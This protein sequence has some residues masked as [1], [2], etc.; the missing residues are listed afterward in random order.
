MATNSHQIDELMTETNETQEPEQSPTPAPRLRRWVFWLRAAFV[1]CLF[2]V[3]FAAAAAVMMVDREITAPTWIK[4]RIEARVGDLLEGATLDFGAIT[5]RIGRDLHPLVR[6][7]DTR[8]ID[9]DGTTISRVPVVEGLMSPRGLILQQD[10]LMQEVRLIG[11]QLNLRRAANGDVS[12]A[13]TGGGVNHAQA[14][15]LPELL[16]QFDQLFETPALEALE[17]V[18]A[19]GMI[20]NFD[21]ARA[22][23]SWIVDGG[24]AVLDLRGG[25]TEIRGDFSLLSGRSEVTIVQL[26]Y[27]S[28]RGSRAAQIGLNLTNAVATDIA[29][30]S[31]GLSWLR[32]IDAPI[33]ASLRT[34]LDE[35][36]ALGP[37]NA[38]LNLGQGAFQPNA[39]ATPVRFDAARAYFTYNPTRDLISFTQ[40][41]VQT[42]WGRFA[43]NGDAYLRDFRDGLPGAILAQLQFQD[44]AINP[45]GFF[46]TPP[47]VSLVTIDLRA[48][49]DPFRIEIGQT[50]LLDGNSRMTAS[51]AI[52]ATDAG[53]DIALDAQID[54][55]TPERF[56]AFWPIP[57]KPRSRNW[58]ATNMTNGQL[59]NLVTGLRLRPER[60]AEFAL[61]F[62]FAG[63]DIKFLRNIPPINGAVGVASIVDN[64]F[65]V[66][67]DEGVVLA[68]QGGPMDLAGSNFAIENLRL[69]PSP[70]NLDLRIDSTLTAALSVLNQPPFEYMDKANLP[71]TIADGLA[72][73]QGR[74][75]WPLMPRPDPDDVLFSMTS[76]LRNVRSETLLPGRQF[77]APELRVTA[78]KA[79]LNIAGS[80]QVGAIGAIGVWDRRFGDPD[81]P[82]SRVLAQVGLSQDFLDEFGIALPPGTI[83]G[84]GTGELAVSLQDNTP[85]AFSLTS[86]LQG[87]RVAIPAVGWTKPAQAT[88]NLRVEGALG[89]VA[90]IDRLEIGGAGFQASG[91][92]D[93]TETGQLQAARFARVQVGNWLDAPVT[94]RGRG[95]GA[96]VGV[97]ISGGSLDLR[98]AQFGGG[99]GGGGPLT[100]GLD[101]LQISDGISLSNFRGD[102]RGDG[103]LRGEFQ[104]QLNGAAP[105]AGTIAPRNG[106]TAVR[107]RSDNAGAV[108]SAAGFMRNAIGG[109]LDLSLLPVGEAGVFDGTLQVRSVRVRDAPTIA[110]LLD[111]ISVVGLLQQMD[112]QGLA[113]EEVD[114]KFR[115]TPTRVIVSEASAVGPGLG[116]SVDG[117]Y[118]LA[119][120]EID[121]QGVVSPFF[122][123]N[124]I[125]SFLTRRGEG[126]IGFNFNI[127]GTSDAPQVSVN[128]L[129]ALTPGMFREI[130]RRPAPDI[131]Q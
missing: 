3:V 16:D 32:D 88:G 14:R 102:F 59:R 70:A 74:I 44:V 24:T 65:A 93:L 115:L 41:D 78:S 71:V 56:V 6:L 39:G 62:E 52:A 47:E 73:T 126:L 10:V 13:F 68:P 89:P 64:R 25:Q 85:P 90:T 108:L 130:F 95:A 58:F 131:S 113:F 103:G 72:L 20:I 28:P 127:R 38:T 26:S 120:K 17:V 33:K 57:M 60:A 119:S 97:E 30:Q 35:A 94:L 5:V 92:I 106:R 22:R 29:S 40:M 82:G 101:Q 98:G 121:L 42:E 1:V 111:A 67:L 100:I 124:S 118:T 46:E 123:V 9:A 80:V 49:F 19:E 51:G 12:F 34:S 128:P 69:N 83:D 50:V 96:P 21:D 55:I 76:Q 122:L 129:S 109:A 63:N 31:P 15:T 53:W 104:G 7:V 36:G 110:A 18:Q 107:L 99:S 4:D 11:A 45:P 105:V 79:G 75:T 27:L 48:R 81:Q 61:G 86:D 91:R 87:V 66:S 125:G 114:A 2:P 54:Q 37:L 117:I 84:R 23:R 116:I 77:A 8:L 43:A 112:G